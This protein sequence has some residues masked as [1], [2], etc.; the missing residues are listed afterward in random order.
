MQVFQ[1][2]VIGPVSGFMNAVTIVNCQSRDLINEGWLVPYKYYVGSIPDLSGVPIIRGEYDEEAA[3]KVMEIAP[4]VESY[5][6]HCMGKK[7]ICYCINVAHSKDVAAQYNAAGIPAV[8]LDATSPQD[9]RD[10]V[11]QDFREGKILIVC[12]VGILTEGADF[13]DC[14]FVQLARPTM[15]LS[16]CVHFAKF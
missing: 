9:V 1:H 14:Q 7:G 10:Q 2:L 12:N 16:V 6:Q 3:R 13:P 15:S 8:H 5:Q 4:I 11:L